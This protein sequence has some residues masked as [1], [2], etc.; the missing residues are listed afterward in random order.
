MTERI[1]R[2]G[3]SQRH[4]RGGVA[5]TNGAGVSG[6]DKESAPLD[7]AIDPAAESERRGCGLLLR[8][9]PE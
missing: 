2:I 7:R 3:R 1:R 4:D 5:G 6:R 8:S 9:R